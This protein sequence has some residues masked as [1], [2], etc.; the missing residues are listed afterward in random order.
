MAVVGANGAGKSTLVKMIVGETRPSNEGRCQFFIHHNL[1]IAYVAQHSFHH[2]ESHY[3]QS[4]ANYIAWRFKDGYDM[5][6]FLSEGYK[7]SPEEAE[8]ADKVSKRKRE[9]KAEREAFLFLL[10]IYI[11]SSHSFFSFLF[12]PFF[13]RLFVTFS[14]S[15]LIRIRYLFFA[16]FGLEGIWSRRMKAG[17]L[18]YE[19][20]K[21]HIPEK[22][23]KYYTREELISEHGLENTLKQADE[24]IAAV[25]A[26]LDLKSVT[27]SEIQRHLDLFGLEKEFG[28]YG[29]IK[30]LSGGQ[31]VKLVLAAAMW[32]CP[33]MI[34][35]D[36]P[37]NY[38]DREALGA[39]S[40]ALNEFGGAV[41]M[42]SHN[43]EFYSSVCSEVWNVENGTVKTEGSSSER[44]MRA[45]AVKQIVEKE[46]DAESIL[47]NAG[48]NA[49][50]NGDKHKDSLQNFWGKAL[51]KKEV[52]NF[53]KA[54]KKKDIK[55]MRAVLQ[56]PCGKVMPGYEHLGDG[57]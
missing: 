12:L 38:L 1:R 39:L 16:Q 56:V 55:A 49:N 7:I 48:G 44:T 27:T 20:K 46:Q 32:N 17:K 57:T 28:T 54:R 35:L 24:K 34:V 15:L 40:L 33:H 5:E 21:R 51:A 23:N 13:P 36:E 14:N 6:K 22:N 18:E 42:I 53:E 52:R 41:L 45:V 37:T 47:D 29:R 3:E 9:R 25:D 11:F 43:K 8:R 26:G 4:P 2:V 50:V 19:V 31:K 30:G 10:K